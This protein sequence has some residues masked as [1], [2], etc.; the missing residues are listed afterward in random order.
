RAEALH[1]ALRDTPE[2]AP[3]ARSRR[4][5]G[6]A[7]ARYRHGDR[8]EALRYAWLAV[9]YAGDAGHVRLRAM[10]LLMVARVSQ[11]APDAE[12]A[13]GRARAI[14]RALE[15]AVLLARCDASERD[16]G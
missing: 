6:I 3:F 14:G 4:A 8:G 1:R 2:T 7:Y 13:R 10:A 9:R 16:R 5:N 12:D 15:D 11:S